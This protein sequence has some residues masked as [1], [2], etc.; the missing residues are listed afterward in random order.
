[1]AKC[2][3]SAVAV[4]TSAI[5]HLI[6]FC[7]PRSSS[8]YEGRKVFKGRRC[9]GRLALRRASINGRKD[10]LQSFTGA[11]DQVAEGIGVA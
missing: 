4:A 8:A 11:K 5:P 7:A 6:S 9:L 10:C 3:V 2:L 1:M